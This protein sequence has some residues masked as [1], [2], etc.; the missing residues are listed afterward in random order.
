MINIKDL[1]AY[2][3]KNPR[4]NTYFTNTCH[5]ACFLGF[6]NNKIYVNDFTFTDTDE[7]PFDIYDNLF[8]DKIVITLDIGAAFGLAKKLQSIIDEGGDIYQF[9]DKIKGAA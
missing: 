7:D 8:D 4:V 2:D 3:S 9:L 6:K 1:T 5:N